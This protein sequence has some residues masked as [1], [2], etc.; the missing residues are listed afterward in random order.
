MIPLVFRIPLTY[1][2]GAINIECCDLMNVRNDYVK[3]S[4]PR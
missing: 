3:E 4:R 1:M 2:R